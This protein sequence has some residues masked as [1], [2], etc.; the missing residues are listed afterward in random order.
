MQE[1]NPYIG[2]PA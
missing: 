1:R 2:Y